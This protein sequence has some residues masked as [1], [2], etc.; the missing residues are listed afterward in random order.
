VELSQEE[1]PDQ[2]QQL[3]QDHVADFYLEPAVRSSSAKENAFHRMANVRLTKVRAWLPGMK[4][5]KKY[6]KIYI[7]LEQLGDETIVDANK[8]DDDDSK[9]QVGFTH[10]SKRI[11]FTYDGTAYGPKKETYE[12]VK[13][14]G[15]LGDNEEVYASIGPFATWRITI[16]PQDNPD[17]DLRHLSKIHLEFHG[18]FLPSQT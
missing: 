16:D 8:S 14:D 15:D 17:L 4:T 2:F 9:S 5:S 18:T 3:Q 6:P 11:L 1:Y 10:Q 13:A 7:L 12:N